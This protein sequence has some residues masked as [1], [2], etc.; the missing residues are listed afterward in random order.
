MVWEQDSRAIVM[1]TGIKERGTPKCARYWPKALYN[2]AAKVGDQQYGA[3]SVAVVGGFKANGFLTTKL[4]VRHDDGGERIVMHYWFNSWPDH[5]VPREPENVFTMLKSVR[6][7]SNNPSQPWV[8]HCS[9]GVGRTGTFITIDHGIQLLDE[10]GRCNVTDII[11]R[12]RKD[13]CAMV[14]HP[15]Q[16]AFA[17]EVLQR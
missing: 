5:G 11:A 15:E 13:R 12:L 2:E 16:A 6:E 3:I 14:Q 8:V 9:A 4:R 10:T 17:H 1:V 7:W